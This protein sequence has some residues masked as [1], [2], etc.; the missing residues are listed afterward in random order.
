[1]GNKKYSFVYGAGLS[2]CG[3]AEVLA[4]SGKPVILY[5]D[6]EKKIATDLKELLEIN[7]GRYLTNDGWQLFLKESFELI[8]SPGIDVCHNEIVNTAKK[9][10]I[11]IYGEVE[12]TSKFYKGKMIGITGTNGKTTTTILAGKMLE[13]LSVPT[14]VAGNIGVSLAKSAFLLPKKAWLV[15]ELSSFQLETVN[16]FFRPNIAVILNLTPDH[17]DRHGSMEK[18]AEAKANIFKNQTIEDILILNYDD[19]LVRNFANKSKSKKFFI[20]CN[21]TSKLAKSDLDCAYLE[22]NNFV[23]KYNGEEKIVAAITDFKLFGKHNYQNA[24]AAIAAAF[25]AGVSINDIKNTL[26]NFAGVEDR[27]EY[28][29]EISGVKYYNDTKATNPDSVIKALDAFTGK[30]VVLI[31][32]GKDKLTDLE[33]F[34]K[35][36]AKKTVG[37]ILIGEARS[38]FFEAA[39]K[40]KVE[41]IHVVDESFKEGVL[42]ANKLAR[43][44][45]VVLLSPACSSFDMF[46]NFP[47]RGRCFKKIV[48]ELAKKESKL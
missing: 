46:K 18:Y 15:A 24:L 10:E 32:G 27:L 40:Y 28:V 5:N 6:S 45:D 11:E 33:E 35:C 31:A 34:M 16:S 19:I 42:L 13:N 38:R 2:G 30:R 12:A 25:F 3:I 14:A 48:F 39:K 47:E 22:N 9:L 26:I 7:G 1:M 23:I 17:L 37:L 43:S 21:E 44:G 8:L 4:K 41:N 29:T 20:S 36:V